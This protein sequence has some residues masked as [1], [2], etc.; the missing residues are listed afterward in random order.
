MSGRRKA[1]GRKDEE[2]FPEKP[3]AHR[4][5]LRRLRQ[6]QWALLP[7]AILVVWIAGY[8]LTLGPERLSG[9]V[10]WKALLDHFRPDRG[11]DSTAQTIV[12]ELR[13]PRI[14]LGI[15]V[16]GA[17]AG[18]GAVYQA[19]FRNPMAD[20]Y[21]IG[22][23]SG[24]ALGA[25]LHITLVESLAPQSPFSWLIRLPRPLY[26]F[27]LASAVV[28]IVYRLS[29]RH[30][31]AHATTLLL[32]GLAMSSLLSAVLSLLLA[33]AAGGA[34]LSE[35]IF[36]LMG[37]LQDRPW[38]DVIGV[39]PAILFG[40]TV[41][42]LCARP[43]N[44]M[45]L[46]EETAQQL[47][48][49]PEVIRR[50]LIGAASLAAAAAVSVS[51]IIGFVGLIIPHIVRRIWGPDHRVLLPASILCGA[52]FLVL[53]DSLARTL[54]SPQEIPVGIIT[55]MTGAPFFLAILSRRRIA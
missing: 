25:V 29:L 53:A 45:L 42:L 37:G 48:V 17:L 27:V 49:S 19:L 39:A 43:L 31:R 35:A 20:P 12:W 36:W 13:A 5:Y 24:A 51:G 41:S 6:R 40:L 22:V 32:T 38:H 4:V 52:G 54:L 34:R 21:I 8:A 11:L 23:S 10:I 1:I 28:A 55:A 18:S 2:S 46:G 3:G 9:A 30:G 50:G 14:V 15:L 26:A 47:G 16:G 33:F 44:L 7:L